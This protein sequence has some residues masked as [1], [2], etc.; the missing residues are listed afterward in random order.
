MQRAVS[1]LKINCLESNQYVGD[2]KHHLLSAVY[3]SS[4]IFPLSHYSAILRLVRSKRSGV[5]NL[6][7][8]VKFIS[9]QMG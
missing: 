4:L 2:F 7:F 8:L 3:W 5:L 9:C 6:L 1:Y